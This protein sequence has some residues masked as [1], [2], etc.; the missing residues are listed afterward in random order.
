MD[1]RCSWAPFLFWNPRSPDHIHLLHSCSQALGH[2]ATKGR[3]QG[4]DTDC[5]TSRPPGRHGASA[6]GTRTGGRSPAWRGGTGAGRTTGG[7]PLPP[8]C[9]RT[10]RL[11][12]RS[13]SCRPLA[14]RYWCAGRSERLPGACADGSGW[15]SSMREWSV[16]RAC[17]DPWMVWAMTRLPDSEVHVVIDSFAFQPGLHKQASAANACWT[18]AAGSLIKLLAP[19]G[20]AW[21]LQLLQSQ[22]TGS[23]QRQ[24]ALQRAVRSSLSPPGCQSMP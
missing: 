1:R 19:A 13:A 6:G 3:A 5:C 7:A 21:R 4:G 14:P 10:Q 16:I 2:H 8:A 18:G 12:R 20:A 17:T 15:P 22:L 24:K 11:R 9:L 23:S